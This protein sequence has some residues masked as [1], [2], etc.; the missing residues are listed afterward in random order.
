MQVMVLDYKST[1]H[2]IK[3]IISRHKELTLFLS[4]S[5]IYFLRGIWSSPKKLTDYNM[6]PNETRM[7]TLYSLAFELYLGNP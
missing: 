6:T 2:T 4:F 1:A 3:S 7:T 5:P